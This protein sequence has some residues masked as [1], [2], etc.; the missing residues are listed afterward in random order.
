MPQP[1][2]AAQKITARRNLLRRYIDLA[3]AKEDQIVY[4]TKLGTGVGLGVADIFT[5]GL[6]T[7][8]GKSIEGPAI[9]A[10]RGDRKKQAAE[11]YAVTMTL[12][13]QQLQG[14][15]L[16]AQTTSDGEP[17]FEW[18][19]SR[20]SYGSNPVASA[21]AAA[22]S[23]LVGS[24]AQDIFTDYLT[25]ALVDQVMSL[26][27]FGIGAAKEGAQL[28]LVTARIDDLRTQIK[29]LKI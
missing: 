21:A 1:L 12:S 19:R 25:E 7:I 5:F 18:L 20:L 26:V 24:A 2:Q 10:A 13:A 4:G 14:L 27:P 3:Y 11:M 9:R 16:T 17:G 15:A 23:N 28:A 29:A 8:V 22:A 6:S